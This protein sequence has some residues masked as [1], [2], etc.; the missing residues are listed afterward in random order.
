MQA[1]FENFGIYVHVPFCA[2]PCGYCRF[3]K[4][5]ADEAEQV[6]YVELLAKE[7][8]LA[9]GELPESGADTMF[10]GGGTPSSLSADSI[11][12]LADALGDFRPKLEWTVE[13]SPSTITREKLAAFKRIGIT[14]ISLGV[15]S[16]D[17]RTLRS[18]GRA[19]TLRSTLDA[20]E[21]VHDEKFPHFSIDLIF[22]AKGQ[23]K[24]MWIAD[25]E[26]AAQCPVDHISAYCLEFESGTSCCGGIGDDAELEKRER[27]GDFF[28]TAM[29]KLPELGFAQ[30]EISNYAKR[31]GECLH[32][33]STWNMAMWRGFGASAASQCNGRR[34]ANAADFDKWARGIESGNPQYENIVPLDD[35]E[36]L[37]STLIFGLRMN[38][39]VDMA[40]LAKRFPHADIKKYSES[41]DFL[42]SQG[43][44]ERSGERIK[45]TRSGRLV[46]DSVAVELL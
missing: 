14:R 36:M 41:L 21:A 16:F 28:E 31:G 26:R 24:D 39:G 44:I 10:W 42:Q 34:F 4:R 38:R 23:T 22:G 46:A 1:I 15:Q 5:R 25:L 18:L 19:H 6:R 3:Y 43:L 20:I 13:V 32:N 8:R 11:E 12:R 9:R 33:L 37:S 2:A 17:E 35:A 45:L 40:S 30:Y 7:V 29:A 27:E